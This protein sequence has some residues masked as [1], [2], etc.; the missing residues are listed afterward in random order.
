MQSN[1]EPPSI[2]FDRTQRL[3]P[4]RFP[5][6]QHNG[7]PLFVLARMGCLAPLQYLIEKGML[8]VWHQTCGEKTAL[9][10]NAD[11]TDT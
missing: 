9:F 3:T 1:G 11:F 2:A 6:H 4:E 10:H 8:F 7:S 5:K